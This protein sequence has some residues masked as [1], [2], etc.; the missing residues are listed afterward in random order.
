MSIDLIKQV[1]EQTGLSLKDIKNAVT[2]LKTDSVDQVIEHLRKQGALKKNSRNDR[3]T[4]NGRIFTYVHEG[5][6]GVM[7]EIKC[8]TDF[9][10]RSDVFA[11]LGDDL[12]LHIA[13]YKPLYV[14]KE[15]APLEYVQKEIDIARSQLILE[16][17]SQ[18]MIDK[19]LEGKKNKILEENALL[20]QQFIKNMDIKVEDRVAEVAQSTGE[21]IEVTKFIIYTLS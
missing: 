5:R 9:V 21:K 18:A 20:S 8:E 3:T 16:N 4:T 12:T 14:S 17:K 10:S 1:R 13:A 15:D 2:E 19:I 7:L 11:T 6:I